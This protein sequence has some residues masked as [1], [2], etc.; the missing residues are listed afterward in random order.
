MAEE[1]VDVKYISLHSLT[2]GL[3]LRLH[4]NPEAPSPSCCT[5]QGTCVP[6][7]G[8]YD[9]G[10]DCLILI[11]FRLPQIRCFTRSLKCFSS[12][13]DSCPHMGIRSLLQF[14]HPPRAGPVLLT[15]LFSSQFLHPTQ[16]CIRYS[17]LL[18]AGVLHAL[19]CLK[20]YSCCICGER[21]TSRPP[22]PPPYCSS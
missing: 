21:Y 19:L 2:V 15:L 3:T 20:V 16:F 8:M 6:V 7:Q 9:C 18:S 22:S 4:H 14:S 10:K 17:C 5:F 13:S 12:D 1:Q 11:P